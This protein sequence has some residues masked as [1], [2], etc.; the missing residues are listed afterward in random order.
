MRELI[1]WIPAAA[2]V[3]ALIYIIVLNIY[4]SEHYKRHSIPKSELDDDT[5]KLIELIERDVDWFYAHHTGNSVGECGYVLESFLREKYP[6]LTEKSVGRIVQTY[7]I[8]DR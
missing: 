1:G 2:L 8:N 6:K 3:L 7:C 4:A 5:I